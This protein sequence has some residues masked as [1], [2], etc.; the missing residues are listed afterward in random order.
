M[1]RDSGPKSITPVGRICFDI[2]SVKQ[3]S[4]GGYKF[5]LFLVDQ[6]TDMSWSYF[7]RHKND[8]DTTMIKFIKYLQDRHGKK[9]ATIIHCDNA[10]E[11]KSFE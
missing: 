2:S 9:K 4:Y 5:W 1:S 3:K 8:L 10:G 7:L 6:Y 11:K